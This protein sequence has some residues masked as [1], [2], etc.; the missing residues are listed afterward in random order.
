[1]VKERFNRKARTAQFTSGVEAAQA[2]SP[3]VSPPPRGE[4]PVI[5]PVLDCSGR[6]C[7]GDSCGS[8]N[9][10][11]QG[12]LLWK[13]F[14]ALVAGQNEMYNT[15]F[16]ATQYHGAGFGAINKATT[17]IHPRPNAE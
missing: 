4:C 5:A 11:Q 10:F 1:M 16:G 15:V 12:S 7:L 3:G 6:R 14:K 8:I 2:Q 13:I 9:D 17:A